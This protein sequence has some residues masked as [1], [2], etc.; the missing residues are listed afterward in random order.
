MR[1]SVGVH[2]FRRAI[3]LAVAL[4]I[5]CAPMS[6]DAE[7]PAASGADGD[8]PWSVSLFGGPLSERNSSEIFLNADWGDST[9]VAG[10]AFRGR[11]AQP[12]RNIDISIELNGSRRGGDQ[13]LWDLSLLGVGSWT[14]QGGDT[15]PALTL[16]GGYGPSWISRELI[17]IRDGGEPLSS[18][19]GKLMAEVEFRPDPS[20][21]FS[22]I[23]RY[24]HRSSAFGVF[25][26]NGQQD[27]GT[28]FLFGGK[29][30]F[31]F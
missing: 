21:P 15:G 19:M 1:G 6:V 14:W 12:W 3:V 29:Y 28:S 8:P 7:D 10:L 30:R 31:G 23:A 17:S 25:G 4:L 26:S 13:Q 20:A 22:L 2:R 16:S 5:A 27:E 9:P 18:W 24:E 11:V